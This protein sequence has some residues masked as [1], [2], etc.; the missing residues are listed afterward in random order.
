MNKII[1][2]PNVGMQGSA[3]ADLQDALQLFLA[4]RAVLANDE[5]TRR[6]LSMQAP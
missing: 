2:P 6:E 1:F 4:R 3:V 5:G